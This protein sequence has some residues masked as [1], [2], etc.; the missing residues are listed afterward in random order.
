[1]QI[2]Q[3]LINLIKNAIEAMGHVDERRIVISTAPSGGNVEVAVEDTGPGL[4][5]KMEDRL[6]TPFCSGKEDGMGVGLS[7]SRTIV[8]AH[9]GTLAGATRD[10]G[11]AIFR[12][13]L[14][15]GSQPD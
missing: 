3:V 14:P 2:Q 1:M 5:I 7:I 6:F 13:T 8:E 15:R 10:E 12:F 11:G 9:G 4:S